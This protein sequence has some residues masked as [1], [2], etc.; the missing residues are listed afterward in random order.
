MQPSLGPQR[1][2]SIWGVKQAATL[3]VA[4][5]MFRQ[6]CNLLQ[7]LDLPTPAPSHIITPTQSL[8]SHTFSLPHFLRTFFPSP[9]SYASPLR[10]WLIVWKFDARQKQG[11]NKGENVDKRKKAGGEGWTKHMRHQTNAHPLIFHSN[12]N[13]HM[14]CRAETFH[15]S[16]EGWGTWGKG[17]RGGLGIPLQWV[18]TLKCQPDVARQGRRQIPR[19]SN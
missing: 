1:E 15:Q 10:I 5:Q 9:V 12:W 17:L 2:V 18:S 16:F 19:S 7:L 3:I 14:Y 13:I 11:K 4:G 6:R 8:F